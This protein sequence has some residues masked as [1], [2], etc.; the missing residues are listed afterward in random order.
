M[1]WTTSLQQSARGSCL[2]SLPAGTRE[3]HRFITAEGMQVAGPDA[4][5]LIA[6]EKGATATATVVLHGRLQGERE[7][8]LAG[9]FHGVSHISPAAAEIQNPQALPMQHSQRLS[10]SSVMPV[11]KVQIT[12]CIAGRSA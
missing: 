11:S 8:T 12:L 10:N 5:T 6:P 7:I 4:A 9:S 1:R 2:L 3:I